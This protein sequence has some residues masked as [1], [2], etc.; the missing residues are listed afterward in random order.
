MAE[1]LTAEEQAQLAE[2]YNSAAPMSQVR[3]S[4]TP[5]NGQ[6]DLAVTKVEPC[7][8]DST[9]EH[10]NPIK[11]VGLQMELKITAPAE[12]ASMP[13][14]STYRERFII[15]TKKDPLAKLPETRLQSMNLGRLK[16]ILR[17]CQC[18]TGDMPVAQIAA[19]LLGK[20]FSNRIE[21]SKSKK[22]GKEYTNLGRNPSP[23]GILPAKLDSVAASA[24]VTAPL[25]NGAAAPAA[26]FGAE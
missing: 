6:Y 8:V 18:P 4:L 7:F 9:D 15:G 19:S 12:I 20:A 16:T 25:A 5:P 11:L 23:L 13:V 3:E 10:N 2:F 14:G 1:T 17:I 21:T 22:D 24:V 26:T